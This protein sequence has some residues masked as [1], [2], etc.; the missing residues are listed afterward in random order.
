MLP[1]TCAGGH[2]ATRGV[3]F[4]VSHAVVVSSGEELKVGGEV[5]VLLVLV[6]LKVEVVEVEVVRLL[7]ENGGD[8]HETAVRRPVDGVVVLLVDGADQLEVT[9]TVALDLLGAEE[10]DGSLGR[11]SRSRRNL[12]SGNEDETVALGFPREVDDCVLDAINDLNWHAL[13]TNA[14]DLEVGGQALLA[15]AVSVDLDA[16]EVGVG[17]PVKLGVGNVEKVAGT[18][19]FL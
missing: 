3:P 9:N 2:K 15:L 16:E 7:A 1:D 12:A 10:A 13:L 17:L 11:D 14:E 5:L 4:D 19:D 8:N 18:D 6:A